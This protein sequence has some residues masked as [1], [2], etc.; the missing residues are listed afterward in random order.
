MHSNCEIRLNYNNMVFG[1]SCEFWE[2]LPN[3]WDKVYS[4]LKQTL[5]ESYIE[6]FNIFTKKRKS[7]QTKLTQLNQTK[8]K[9]FLPSVISNL[10][11]KYKIL[12]FIV[13]LTLVWRDSMFLSYKELNWNQTNNHKKNL[14]NVFLEAGSGIDLFQG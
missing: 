6:N 14:R 12:V 13:Q 9:S 3:Y 10:L 11:C 5:L 7:K 2:M 4:A 8:Y 1:I